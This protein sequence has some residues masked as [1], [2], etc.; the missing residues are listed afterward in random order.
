MGKSSVKSLAGLVVGTLFMVGLFLQPFQARAAV[1]CSSCYPGGNGGQKASVSGAIPAAREIATT[2]E[3]SRMLVLV[4]HERSKKGLPALQV[5]SRLVKVAR[6]R[7]GQVVDRGS[8]G[9]SGSLLR[10]LKA[11]GV[12]CTYA[13]QTVVQAPSVDSAYRALI[14]SSSYLQEILSTRYDR[15]GVG[16][17]RKGSRLYIVQLLTGGQAGL[18]RTQP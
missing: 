13:A 18:S 5:D 9:L 12:G 15:I 4:N 11:E 7:A 17:V 6:Q 8:G 3:E 10:L 16:V 2:P 1:P 14:K